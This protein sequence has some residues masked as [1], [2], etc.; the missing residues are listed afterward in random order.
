M[1]PYFEL[2]KMSWFA[3]EKQ[4]SMKDADSGTPK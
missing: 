3:V 1:H 4:V 2:D